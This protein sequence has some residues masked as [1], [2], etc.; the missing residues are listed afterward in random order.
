M[1]FRLFVQSFFSQNC[2]AFVELVACFPRGT[3]KIWKVHMMCFFPTAF[4]GS[5]FQKPYFTSFQCG[6]ISQ[7]QHQPQDSDHG[8]HSLLVAGT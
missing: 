6:K 4:H 7:E 5:A 2:G 8:I 3:G 1:I